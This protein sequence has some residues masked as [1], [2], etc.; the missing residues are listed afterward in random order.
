MVRANQRTVFGHQS[1]GQVVSLVRA[2]LWHGNQPGIVFKHEH[3]RF[4]TVT[5]QSHMA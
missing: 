5:L 3:R 4:F 2:A 1:L